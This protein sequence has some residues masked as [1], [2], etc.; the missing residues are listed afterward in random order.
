MNAPNSRQNIKRETDLLILGEWIGQGA[1]VLDLG[2]GRGILL[3][4]LQKIKQV[5]AV[6]VDMDL[7][8]VR[9]CVE[10][11]VSV[12]QGDVRK[13]LATFEKEGV[14][15][16][17]IVCSRTLEELDE[18]GEL[19]ES[20]LKVGKRLAVSFANYG[21]WRNRLHMLMKGKRARSKTYEEAGRRHAHVRENTG[22]PW[23]AAHPSNPVSVAAF[24][25]FCQTRSLKIHRRVYL[26]GDW[27]KPCRWLPN[28]CAGYAVYEVSKHDGP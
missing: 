22:L 5:R 20:A 28:L 10:R 21:N 18:P 26:G 19:L 25:E 24:E 3:E 15:F 2:C 17:W 4:H 8:K 1:S 12:M 23:Y 13:A 7:G 6:G 11:G 16:D 9:G 27:E 14:H